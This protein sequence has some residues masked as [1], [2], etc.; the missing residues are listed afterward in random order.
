MT[1]PNRIKEENSRTR[2]TI[3]MVLMLLAALGAL[4]S[5]ITAV[6]TASSAGPDTQQVEWWRALGFLM[7]ASL[8]A[9]LAFWPRRYPYLWEILILNKAALT[10]VMVLL[11]QNNAANAGTAAVADGILTIILLA[12]YLLSKGYLSWRSP[13]RHNI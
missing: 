2:D 12:A 9:L 6:G 13:N 1:N 10:I 3:A 11:A 7:F 4:Y 8:F 5:F